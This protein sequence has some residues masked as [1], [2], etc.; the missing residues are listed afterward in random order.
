MRVR[1]ALCLTTAASLSLRNYHP[2]FLGP[3]PRISLLGTT[4]TSRALRPAEL[5]AAAAHLQA[6]DDLVAT[7]LGITTVIARP[8]WAA[9]TSSLG[10]IRR[11]DAF[12]WANFR[13][14]SLPERL[15]G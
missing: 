2:V 3:S 8:S 5:A 6:V 4:G 12:I 9:V 14:K 10:A 11:W 15:V 7:V 13:L 1:E